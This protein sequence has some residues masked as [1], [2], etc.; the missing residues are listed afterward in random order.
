MRQF[1]AALL[2]CISAALP[3][4][5]Q[6]FLDRLQKQ[7]K[8]QGKITVT[9][10]AAIDELVNTAVLSTTPAPVHK[11]VETVKTVPQTETRKT[12]TVREN[13]ETNSGHT[14]KTTPAKE[15]PQ[16]NKQTAPTREQ[17]QH[18]KQTAAAKETEKTAE[19]ED[20]MEIPVIDM[21]KKVMGK[22]YKVTGYRVQAFAGG[23]TRQD[24]QKA[25]KI[26]NNIKMNFPDTPIYVHFY[27]PRWIC[28]VGNYRTYEEA[29][30]M[31]VEVRRMGY[32][33]ASIVKGKISVQY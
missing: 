4:G 25:E 1:V 26:G 14:T 11:Q 27:S 21:R 16:H 19:G 5:A 12:T 24:R 15:Q 31:L 6:S 7:A 33:S 32:R 20:E 28:R 29:H 3:A 23:N 30:R 22:S 10:D 9:Q 17:S 8:G 2:I 18:N 13:R